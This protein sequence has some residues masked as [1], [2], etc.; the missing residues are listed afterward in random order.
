MVTSEFKKGKVQFVGVKSLLGKRC[1]LRNPWS[2]KVKV[3]R[4][5]I[6]SKQLS[7]ELLELATRKDEDIMIIPEGKDIVD[8]ELKVSPPPGE[9]I[10]E[11]NIKIADKKLNVTVG[12]H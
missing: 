6:F 1:L 8:L 10:W 11:L 3:Y 7:G 4:N 12:K 5:G 9:G 2:E